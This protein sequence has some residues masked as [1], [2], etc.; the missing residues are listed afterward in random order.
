[1]EG[2][3]VSIGAP[4]T[5]TL[6]EAGRHTHERLYRPS[7]GP[8]VPF[9]FFSPSRPS[10]RTPTPLAG[11]PFRSLDVAP[12]R[13]A[14]SLLFSSIFRFFRAGRHRAAQQVADYKNHSTARGRAGGG[15]SGGKKERGRRPRRAIAP[16]GA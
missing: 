4:G 3:S 5:E 9:S 13:L 12:H 15:K 11:T 6:T 7:A 10:R 8:A 14:R 1:M 16:A 2:K